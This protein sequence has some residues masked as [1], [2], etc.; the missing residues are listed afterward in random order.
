MSS[1]RRRIEVAAG[2]AC[3]LLALTAF[4]TPAAA[5]RNLTYQLYGSRSAGWGFTST[6]LTTPGPTLEVEVGDNVTLNLT[7]VDGL[8]HRWFIDYNNNSG[9]DPSEP[10]SGNFGTSV[11]WNFTV[12][13]VTGT[14]RYRSDRTAG[15]GDD[16]ANMWG[17]ITI[18]PAGTT[19]AL[20]GGNL[21]LILGLVI[22]FV[23]ILAIAA[24]TYRRQRLPPAPPQQ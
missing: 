6:S 1:L 15:P 12:S 9:A 21:V 8:S 19:P 14:F 23:G 7:S 5:G 4:A 16:L 13:N 24:Y 22:A 2:L 18:R 17:N 10:R 3:L 11:H 20:L